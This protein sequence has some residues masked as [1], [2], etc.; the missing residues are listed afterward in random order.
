MHDDLIDAVDW[1]VE[2][3]YADP[4][5]VGIYGGSYGGYAALVAVTVTPDRFAAAVDYVG[6]SDLANFLRTLPEFTR[7]FSVNNWFRYVGD[8][9]VPEQE[10]D[11]LARSPIT[12]VE[13]IRTP[14][15]VAQGAN[16]VRVVRAESDN[17]VASLRERGVPVEYL[18]A[19]D[20]GHGFENPENRL[21]L[22]RAIEA[23]FAE[24]LGG[25]R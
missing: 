7:P 19:D 16:D 8:P 15:L 10:A 1:A 23:H 24:H 3:G 11:M 22:Y 2:R 25:G 14:L 6:I 21:R 9:A 20:E 13:R 5:R 4:D 12:M 18:V 17:I